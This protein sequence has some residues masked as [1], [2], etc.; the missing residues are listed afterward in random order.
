MSFAALFSTAAGVTVNALTKQQLTRQERPTMKNV[1][2]L[3]GNGSQKPGRH[4]GASRAAAPCQQGKRLLIVDDDLC[5]R[6][7]T[8]LFLNENGY[9]CTTSEN[10]GRAIDHLKTD[11]F[12][13]VIT[14][15]HMPDM[16]GLALLEW[17]KRRL[18]AT[19]VMMMTGDSNRQFKQH[20][21]KQGVANYLVKP[22]TLEKF[23]QEI[24]G[25]LTE[26]L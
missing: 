16:D 14:D 15:L 1:T 10:A 2:M 24:E 8:E 6:E 13:L 26:S 5:M 3:K 21:V 23:L 25:C 11:Q 7:V 19:K 22:F 17:I 4:P 12:D 9:A 20:A 18:P